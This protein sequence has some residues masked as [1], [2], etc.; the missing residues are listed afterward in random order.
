RIITDFKYQTISADPQVIDLHVGG[1]FNL[2]YLE[3]KMMANLVTRFPMSKETVI[4]D[5]P[6][7]N[8]RRFSK[9]VRSH[10]IP[11]PLIR[12]AHKADVNYPVVSAASIIAKVQRDRQIQNLNW[13]LGDIGSGYPSDPKTRRFLIEWVIK[14]NGEIPLFARKS[15]ASWKAWRREIISV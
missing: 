12:S 13:N 8:T 4:L 14:H 2:N 7:V 6:D 3:A 11:S 1:F 9:V 10:I 5:C 15:W